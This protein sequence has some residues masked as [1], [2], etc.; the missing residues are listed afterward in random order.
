MNFPSFGDAETYWLLGQSC[1]KALS[2]DF[3]ATCY[4]NIRP[5]GI[6]FYF[7]LPFLFTQDQVIANYLTLLLNLLFL[8]LLLYSG[9]SL[10][11]QFLQLH[12]APNWELSVFNLGQ[13]IFFV[14]TLTL[15]I[16]YLPVRLSDHQSL[17]CFM[18]SF[19]LLCKGHSTACKRTVFFSGLLSGISVLLKQN[20][21]VAVAALIAGLFLTLERGSVKKSCGLAF[22]YVLGASSALVQMLWVYLHSG[23]FWFYDPASLELYAPSNAQPFVELIAYSNP[24]QSAYLTK[25][26]HHISS[27][28]YFC[29]KF[30]YGFSK[31]YWS[32][33]LGDLPLTKSPEVVQ[34]YSWLGLKYTGFFAVVSLVSLSS[35]CVRNRFLSILVFCA[36]CFAAFSSYSAHV[37]S[38]YFY[39]PKIGYLIFFLVALNIILNWLGKRFSASSI[40][41]ARQNIDRHV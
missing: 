15:S 27:F 20:Y 24:I 21:I 33:Y 4:N 34:Y 17:A 32:I 19:V 14:T 30:Y 10:I 31:F 41:L 37:E 22:Y 39:F 25:L 11:K 40:C 18:F 16:A 36:Y 3:A 1:A 8:F 6:A 29:L 9:I 2:G 28:E 12:N 35:L 23:V 5:I 26:S 7:A 38:R 13:G